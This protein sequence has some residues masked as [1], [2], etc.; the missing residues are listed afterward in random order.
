KEKLPGII[1]KV[2]SSID[3]V[4]KALEDVQKTVANTRD[5]SGS[6]KT[7][8][9]GNRG[10]LDGVIASVKTT[11]DNLKAASAEIR[12]SPWRLLYQPKQDELSNL[13]LYDSARQFAEGAN[14]LNDAAQ[15]LRDALKTGGADAKKEEIDRLV[16]RLKTSADNFHG[17]GQKLWQR[18]KD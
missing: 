4:Q 12:R 16:E 15:A 2:E 10:K 18:V 17:V 9:A 14:D 7:L 3:G 11:A 6:A 8:L 1:T 13:N 5:I